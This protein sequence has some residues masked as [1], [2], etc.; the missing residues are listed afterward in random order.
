VTSVASV[1]RG[2]GAVRRAW[3]VWLLVWA[4]TLACALFIALPVAA[5]LYARLG[6]SLYAGAM[7][8]NFDIQWLAEFRNASGNWPMAA[9][10]PALVLIFVAYL[11]M[12]TFVSGGALAVFTGDE[13]AFWPGCGR[14]FW[15]LL[16]LLLVSLVCYA[17]VFALDNLLARTGHWIWDRGMLERPVVI[18]GWVRAAIAL[19]LFLFVNMVFDYAKI[20]LVAENRLGALAA[21]RAA[22]QFVGRR[23]GTTL[24]TYG[25]ISVL[26]AVLAGCYWFLSGA[27][28][29]TAL[30][31]LALV[32][33]LQQAFVAGRVWLKLLYLAAQVEVWRRCGTKE[34][35]RLRGSIDTPASN[36]SSAPSEGRW[37]SST[38]LR[39]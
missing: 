22:F 5:V 31:W 38:V 4:L 16:R 20:R 28:P 39:P 11:L 10:S 3:R 35:W 7:F 26:A 14:Y 17:V 25:L 30:G 15:R 29:R 2:A 13:P 19:L 32:L 8:Q 9:A 33:I 18:F 37:A 27:L 6:H 34:A 12:A 21:A 24:A 23:P 36:P 1:V